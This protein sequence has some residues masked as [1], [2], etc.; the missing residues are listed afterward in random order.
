MEAAF[1]QPGERRLARRRW[2]A[3]IKRVWSVDPLDCP[4]GGGRPSI[5]SFIEPSQV[6]VIQKILRHC[7]RWEVSS[8]APPR[9]PVSGQTRRGPE[10]TDGARPRWQAG[11]SQ[12]LIQSYIMLVVG[13]GTL[14]RSRFVTMR[15]VDSVR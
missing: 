12:Q 4:R 1:D 11:G 2:A 3:L 15:Q 5:V 13:G 10:T 7:G 6:D 9:I 8:R 14:S